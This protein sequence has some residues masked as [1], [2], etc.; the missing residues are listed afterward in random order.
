MKCWSELHEEAIEYFGFFHKYENLFLNGNDK[1]SAIGLNASLACGLENRMLF[2]DFCN[3]EIKNIFSIKELNEYELYLNINIEVK[4]SASKISHYKKVW[5]LLNQKWDLNNFD[6]NQEIAYEFENNTTYS[7]IAKFYLNDLNTALQ[8]MHRYPQIATIIASRNIYIKEGEIV[9]DLLQNQIR[10]SIK[11]NHGS[12]DFAKLCINMDCGDIVFRFG[13]GG[14]DI[15][16][17]MI[18]RTKYLAFLKSYI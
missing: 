7:G 2:L 16:L 4:H 18:Y 11:Y 9:E 5:K 1:F 15:E 3:E 6:K 14:E 8:I 12:I 13:D 17:C 10:A